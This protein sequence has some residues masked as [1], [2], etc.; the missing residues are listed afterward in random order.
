[1]GKLLRRLAVLL[2]LRRFESELAEELQFH[3]EMKVRELDSQSPGPP[4]VHVAARRTLGSAVLARNE[5]RDVW[6]WPALQ[7]V[8]QDVRFAARL[9][10]RE[11]RFTLVA[12]LVLGVGIGV[13]NML[14]TI[15]N[16]HTIRGLP[17]D[18]PD[19]VL[20]VSTVDVQNRPR[21]VS[22]PDFNDLRAATQTFSA[23][24]AFVNVPVTIGEEGRAPERVDGAYLTAH[25]FD[26]VKIKPIAGRTFLPDED[27]PGAAPVI[28][29][30]NSLWQ[31]RYSGA[32]DIVGQSIR[33]NGS[34]AT[35]IGIISDRSGLPSTAQAWLPL[36]LMPDLAAGRRDMRTLRV[37]GRVRDGVEPANARTEVEGLLERLQSDHPQTNADIRARVVP[38]NEQFIGRLSDPAWRAFITV[39]FL[40]LAISCANVAN[41]FLNHSVERTREIAI[42]TALGATRPRVVR[43][44]LI[45][46]GV[47]A[48]ASAIL[49]LGIAIA[50]VQLFGGLIPENV[51]P[52]WFD[53]SI[54]GRVLA[55]LV[56]VSMATVLVFGLIPAISGSKTDVNRALKDNRETGSR[57]TRR[58]TAVF[59]TAEFALAVVMLVQIGLGLR[60]SRPAL[61]SDA[62]IDT[63]EV[64]TAAITLSGDRYRTPDQRVEFVTRVEEQLNT[65]IEIAAASVTNVLPLAGG[66]E[67]EIAIAGQPRPEPSRL[68]LTVAIGPGYFR[69]FRLGM[70]RGREFVAE[71]GI[72]G[73]A[74]VIIN[75]RAAHLYF[76][77]QDAIGQRIAFASPES[78]DAALEWLTVVGVAPDIRQQARPR[79]PGAWETD[80]VVYLPYRTLPTD[81]AILLLRGTGDA[82]TLA[83]IART[84]LLELDPNVPLYRVRTMAGVIDDGGWNARVSNLLINVLAFIAVTLATM[85]LYAVTAHGVYQRTPELGLRMALGA[86][87]WDI[88]RLIVTRALMHAS[89][90]FVVGVACTVIWARLFWTGAERGLVT[91]GSLATVVAAVVLLALAASVIPVV[92]ATRLDPIAALRYE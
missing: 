67:R 4:D 43:Q 73:Q 17:I 44:L 84:R 25:A 47:L 57:R 62:A 27:R 10:A 76:G 49:G 92:R 58:W 87:R 33:V 1:M 53:Y 90:G 54:D 78:A 48:A 88:A 3:Y 69:T 31:A 56:G 81:T 15:L 37:F 72:A 2:R 14:F 16:A 75:E 18:E 68:A 34:P 61:P 19:R 40:V 70:R 30:G 7:D 28:L 65:T 71:D 41:L 11:R 77:D 42:R 63:S 6:V 23:I 55:M 9:L 66:R 89:A 29:L 26:I 36:S 20:Y 12:V 5:S 46:A 91:V 45:E 64:L 32:P 52:Y 22:F 86:Q 59:L 13:N 60:L 74:H 85:G 51:L 80:P 82:G 21:G 38:I 8:A 79:A 24:A 83:A 50:G 39:G 35:V